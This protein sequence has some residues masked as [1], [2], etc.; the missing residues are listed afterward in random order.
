M[1]LITILTDIIN[2]QISG[3]WRR[4][5]NINEK[6]EDLTFEFD[7][8]NV[9]KSKGIILHEIIT[10][11]PFYGVDNPKTEIKLK[12]FHLIFGKDS[13][14]IFDVFDTDE[15]AGLK[16]ID[17][18]KKIKNLKNNGESEISDA[19]IAGLTNVFDGEIFIFINIERMEEENVA[20]GT[21]PHE[22][23][24]LT[25]LLLTFNETPKFDLTNEDWWEKVNFLTLNDYNEETFSE[26]LEKCTTIV[27]ERYNNL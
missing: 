15:I 25:R 19:F 3:E 26:V 1:K 13:T 21:I 16:K 24:H 17:A 11:L 2:E 9:K 7:S 22:C 23:L 8:Q 4:I 18:I 10:I 5:E 27:F 20:L 6:I 14:S 12:P